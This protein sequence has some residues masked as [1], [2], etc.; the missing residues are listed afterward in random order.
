MKQLLVGFGVLVVFI[1]YALG[2]RHEQP[3]LA[4]PAAIAAASTN[5]HVAS[6]GASNNT[7][8][9]NASSNSQNPSPGSQAS[10]YRN[11]T[12]TGSAED[13]YYGNV[14]VAATITGGK[15]T[16]VNFLQYP[17]THPDSVMINQQ[18]MPWLKQEAIQ[19]QSANVD[20]ISGATFTSQA[21]TQSLANALSQAT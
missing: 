3:T 21:F 8:T 15:I 7:G 18:A 19:K 11:G 13:A 16:D 12:Y 9:G 14:Q 4:K 2:V 17:D 5:T 1:V 20:I 10:G 6:G